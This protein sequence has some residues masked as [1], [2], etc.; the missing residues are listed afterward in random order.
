MPMKA[1]G[2]APRSRSFALA[3]LAA[4]VLAFSGQAAVSQTPVTAKSLEGVWKVTKVVMPGPNGSI[5]THPQPSLQIFYQ[6]YFSLVRD[7]GAAPRQPSPP[8]T[9]PSKLTDEEKLARYAEWAPF[10]AAAGTYE[11]EGDTL[12]KA[13]GVGLT[14]EAT[15]VFTGDTFVA[16]AKAT[17]GAPNAGRQTTYTRVR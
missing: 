13:G 5:D 12:I 11:V 4:A 7:N 2:P 1:S 14:E 10:S 15:I 6:G 17:G 9:D 16:T 8:V 3:G